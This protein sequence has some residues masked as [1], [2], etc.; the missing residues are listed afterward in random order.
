MSLVIENKKST[1]LTKEQLINAVFFFLLGIA[2]FGALWFSVAHNAYL[3]RFDKPVLDW[4]LA[5]RSDVLTAVMQTIT[6]IASPVG[7]IGIVGVGSILWGLYKKEIWR[8][9]LLLGAMGASFV[10][11]TVVKNIVHRGRPPITS[12][13]QPFETDYSF[14]SGHTIGIAVCLFVL[15]YLIYSRAPRF[16]K[17]VWLLLTTIIGIGA[18]AISRLYL[19]YHWITDV[20][21]SI[22]LAFIVL[23]IIIVIDY[24]FEHIT[25][26]KS[27]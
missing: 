2:I 12:M 10:I 6:N 8:P 4:M 24:I 20:T 22:G 19:G 18:V 9:F 25:A 27:A 11:S 13:I 17:L 7:F 14:P 23:A 5:H 26:K 16:G 21:A 15:S 3:V 1:S